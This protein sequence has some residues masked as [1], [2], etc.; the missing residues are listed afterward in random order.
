MPART[1]VDRVGV[2]GCEVAECCR[3]FGI[4]AT[5]INVLTSR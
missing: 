2:L 3:E 1:A 5:V 4:E